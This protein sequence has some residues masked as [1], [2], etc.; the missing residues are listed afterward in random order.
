MGNIF[1][2]AFATMDLNESNWDRNSW[3][4]VYVDVIVFTNVNCT[5]NTSFLQ[6]YFTHSR[7]LSIV[8]DSS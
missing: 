1:T 8:I 7:N 6:R 5:V 4:L 3:Y 2:D